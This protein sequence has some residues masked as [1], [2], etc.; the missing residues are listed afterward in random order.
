MGQLRKFVNRLGLPDPVLDAL[1][2][3][4]TMKLRGLYHKL[5]LS[6]CGWS[7]TIDRYVTIQ[8]GQCV[9]MGDYCA[10]NAYTH[11]WGHKG[12]TIGNRVMIASHV[13]ITSLTHDYSRTDMRFAPAI[14]AAVKIEDD[15]WIGAHAVIMPGV[16]IGEGAVVGAGAVVR[17]N[18]PPFAIVVGVPARIVRYRFATT[19][20]SGL[21]TQQADLSYET[22]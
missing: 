21:I 12:V 3:V 2:P 13:S 20:P 22:H 1:Y 7:T 17:E 11:I 6:K 10:I 4:R 9:T 18:V 14:G 19:D 5:L 15:V 8:G 16:T